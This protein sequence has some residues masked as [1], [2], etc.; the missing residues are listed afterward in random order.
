MQPKKHHNPFG[1]NTVKNETRCTPSSRNSDLC[2]KEYK[3]G[4]NG[5]QPQNV[6]TISSDH[7][8]THYNPPKNRQNSIEDLIQPQTQ[9]RQNRQ[10][11]TCFPWTNGKEHRTTMKQRSKPAKQPMTITCFKKH[12]RELEWAPSIDNTAS[13]G[14]TLITIAIESTTTGSVGKIC[15]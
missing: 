14:L 2:L 8:S 7:N 13:T 11:L 12:E 6:N 15:T 5:N 9:V 1:W 10:P 4:F 3:S